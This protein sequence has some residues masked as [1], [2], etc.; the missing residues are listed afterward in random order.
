MSLHTETTSGK[1]F[2]IFAEG[3]L[4]EKVAEG[5]PNA[6][7]REG[8]TPSGETFSKWELC[9]PGITARITSVELQKGNYGKQVL[10]HMTDEND[11]QFTVALG[12]TTKHGTGFM[13]LLPNLDLTKEVTIKAF[14]DF[15]DKTGREVRGGLSITQDGTKVYSYFYDAEK[16]KNL[17]GMPEPE[18][19]K[20]TKEVDWDS[21]W[22]IRD[23]WLMDYL[24]DNN[25]MTYV[26][27]TAEVVDTTV[28]DEDESF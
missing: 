1:R 27:S 10:I 19:D 24:L 14:G 13:Q 8:T 20:R 12:A 22:P 9:Y 5:T 4:R 25:Y 2:L 18:V 15:K 3:K 16:K 11:E 28:R 17:H 6:V 21:Y 23:K 26:D 7:L